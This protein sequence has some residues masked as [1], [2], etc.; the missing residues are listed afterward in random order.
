MF[1]AHKG[2]IICGTQPY[3]HILGHTTLATDGPQNVLVYAMPHPGT[4]AW[5]FSCCNVFAE[6]LTVPA[7]KTYKV[8]SADNARLTDS[9]SVSSVQP[10]QQLYMGNSS[11]C[12]QYFM[13]YTKDSSSLGLQYFMQYP[14]DNAT[15]S[16]NI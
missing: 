11:L 5:A 8:G 3:K 10:P 4:D 6:T 15:V 13:Q 12:L 2:T 7:V 1:H 9:G 14:K 16:M